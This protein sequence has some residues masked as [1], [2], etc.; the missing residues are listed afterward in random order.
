MH[1]TPE[2][3]SLFYKAATTTALA[4][5]SLYTPWEATKTIGS[6][7]LIG[8]GYGIVNELISS[9]CCSELNKKSTFSNLKHNSKHLPIQDLHPSLN[10]IVRGMFDYWRVSSIAGITLA[11][12]ARAPLFKVKI[13]AVQ[14]TPYLVI[15]SILVTLVVQIGNRI[16]RKYDNIIACNIQH[17]ASYG[18]LVTG[19]MLLTAAI[20]TTRIGLKLIK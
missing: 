2:H 16:L 1:I 13:Q 20:L 5:G 14:I 15:G 9:W 19:N 7:T 17:A 8:I 12:A 18:I 3:K 6:T 10:A 4:A 11:L